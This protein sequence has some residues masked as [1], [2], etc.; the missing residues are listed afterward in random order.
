MKRI[1]TFVLALMLLTLALPASAD[2]EGWY[3]VNSSSPNGYTYLYS[4]ASDRDGISVNRGRYNN[5]EKVYVW[6]YHGG[7]DG[8]YN[9][10]RVETVDG[11]TGYMH[12]Y[13]LTPY[14]G[15]NPTDTGEGW[16]VISSTRPNGYAYLYSAPSDRSS[17]GYNKGPYNNGEL[18][19][20][21]DYYGGQDGSYNYCHVKTQDGK[22][23]YMHDSA[24]VRCDSGNGS[25]AHLSALP[26]LSIQCRGTVLGGSAS[27]YTGP[28]TAYY[29]TKS[30][31]AYVGG[32]ATI[33]VLGREG[34]YYLVMYTGSSNGNAVTR[35][36]FVQVGRLAPNAYVNDLDLD[37]TAITLA[38]D[39]HLVDG[40]D[41]SHSFTSIS[42]N[43]S[44]AYA[45]AQYR[46]ERGK[47]WVYFEATGY[48]A[49]QG[50]VSVR[51]FAPME[52]VALR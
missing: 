51:G 41:A 24:L 19:Y 49:A 15:A 42:I 27:V 26:L 20:V 36:S 39:A 29:R 16:Y 38:A 50:T 8:K 46:D 14:Y 9:Y 31:T 22:T 48:S 35:C 25:V 6:E 10:C 43:R 47:A 3:V 45:L 1:L 13:A 18:V 17:K 12:D 7:Q 32:G 30:G 11:K 52:D 4:N 2:G 28:S 5:G 34:D 33:D 37:W 21:L 44:S 40:P 23:G